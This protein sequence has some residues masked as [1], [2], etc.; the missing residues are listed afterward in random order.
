MKIIPL[1]QQSGYQIRLD[2]IVATKELN[3]VNVKIIT[4][5]ETSKEILIP[6][7]VISTQG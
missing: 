5:V 4:D 1:P 7:R 3:G 2:N 6:F